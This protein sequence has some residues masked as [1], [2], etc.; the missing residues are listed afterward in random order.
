MH[1]PVQMATNGMIE[2]DL[3]RY[4]EEKFKRWRNLYEDNVVVGTREIVKFENMLEGAKLNSHI[5]F[6]P[7][8]TRGLDKID[9]KSHYTLLIYSNQKA[10]QKEEPLYTFDTPIVE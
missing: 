6:L 9:G 8:T 1:K 10:V 2:P 7:I 3:L 4:I 5:G